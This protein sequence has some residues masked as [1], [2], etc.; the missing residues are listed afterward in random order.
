M[1]WLGLRG[2][3]KIAALEASIGQLQE[4][5]EKLRKDFGTLDVEM[6]DHLDRLTGIAKRFTG[7][8]GG[9][10]PAN[11]NDDANGEAEAPV[12]HGLGFTRHVL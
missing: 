9:R 7:R 4:G 2:R 10:P 5:L 11:P 12:Q 1:L 6:T 3:A 8:K